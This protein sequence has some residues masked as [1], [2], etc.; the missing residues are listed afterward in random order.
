M[1][2]LGGRQIEIMDM[3]PPEQKIAH[4]TANETG[5]GQKAP[6]PVQAGALGKLVEKCHGRPGRK[7]TEGYPAL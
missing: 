4:R 7:I 5:P 1:R 6:E 2:R 3:L